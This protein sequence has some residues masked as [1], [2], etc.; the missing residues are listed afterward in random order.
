MLLC[1]LA[2]LSKAIS[3]V[4][5]LCGTICIS[6]ICS[7]LYAK[8]FAANMGCMGIHLLAMSYIYVHCG[9]NSFHFTSLCSW[10]YWVNFKG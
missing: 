6:G 10:D 2:H 4:C 3:A 8:L 7:L 5:R 9:D 1:S